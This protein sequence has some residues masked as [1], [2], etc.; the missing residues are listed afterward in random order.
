MKKVV[1]TLFVLTFGI[2]LV[3][4]FA[5]NLVHEKPVDT[6]Y[7]FAYDGV[8]IG[9]YMGNTPD[10]VCSEPSGA[11]CALGFNEAD[12]D[13]SGPEP[14]LESGVTSVDAIDDAFKL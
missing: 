10:A 1:K 3:T 9:A 6:I 8:Q 4:A 2:A 11:Q 5:F 13:A 12:V 14:V 7:W